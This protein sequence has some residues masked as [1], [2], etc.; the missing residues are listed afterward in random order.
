MDGNKAYTGA[1]FDMYKD[2]K[3]RTD[4]EIYLGIVGPVR[5]GKSTFIRRFMELC[6]LPVMLDDN[7]KNRA[8][9]ELPQAS[10]GTTIM[11]TEPKFIPKEA[12]L[13]SPFE[14]INLKVRMVDCV[15]Y[16]IAGANGHMENGV[17]RM[18]KTPWTKEDIPFSKAAEIG[19]RK[20]IKEHSTIGIVV[21]TDGSITGIER[22]DYI[23]A[24]EK[25]I[26]ELQDI[27]KP[28]VVLLNCVKPYS[29][30]TET[31]AKDMALKYKVPVIP[32]NCDQLKQEDVNR[33]F[34]NILKE[35]PVRQIDFHTP[36]WT[37][38]LPSGHWL[39]KELCQAA[40][41]VL[42]D[43]STIKDADQYEYNEE[44]K[45]IKQ[46]TI[47]DV[48]MAQ[49]L[50]SVDYDMNQGIYYDILSE[51]T[52]TD[53]KNEY[54]LVSTIKELSLRRKE[55]EG[56][57]DA[58]SQVNMSGFGVVTPVR[59]AIELEEPVVIKN[60][61]KY[62]VK[63]KA[64]VPSVNLLKTQINV[65]IAPIVGTKNQA[66]DL[67][68]YIRTNTSDNPDGIWDTS[69]FGKTIE[70]IVD[71]GIYEKTHNI[72]KENMDKISETIEKVMNENSGLVCLI[73]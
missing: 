70:Q 3:N 32:V 31:L 33:I 42:E 10:G 9:D 11:T 17:E 49:G 21:T 19:T 73:V 34:E 37:E 51:L 63:I 29:K 55:Y 65:E 61:S 72:T 53:I 1:G 60:G 48:D 54:E 58:M 47:S 59:S 18:V 39:K 57:G 24:E 14:G 13:I 69:I 28:F 50:V 38:V 67:I 26:A 27:N 12:A 46:L 41:R 62:G 16:M 68:S 35:F 71:D 22:K 52:G 66:E 25:T 15:G 56:I 6:V 64:K 36:A 7:E 30:E 20:V 5:T 40:V 23:P 43:I 4:G 8:T 44:D 2:I 45:Y